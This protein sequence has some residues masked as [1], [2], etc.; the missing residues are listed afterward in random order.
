VPIHNGTFDLAMHRWEEPFE[1]VTGLALARGIAVATPRIGE[2]VNI[3]VPHRG[4]RWWRDV[5]KAVHATG[6]AWRSC[7][8]RDTAQ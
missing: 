2:R 4:E 6:R 5:P 3:E 8:C 1:R 7:A